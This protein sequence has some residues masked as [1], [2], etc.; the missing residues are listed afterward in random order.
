MEGSTEGTTFDPA[1]RT[2]S[3][4]LFLDVPHLYPLATPI[5]CCYTF[6]ADFQPYP[7]DWVGIFKVSKQTCFAC[8]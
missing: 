3:Q 8:K 5:T 6:T 7:R 2:F 1:A 4:V